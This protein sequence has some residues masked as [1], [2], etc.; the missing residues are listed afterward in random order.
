MGIR[1]HIWVAVPFIALATAG[2]LLVLRR[3]GYPA[4]RLSCVAVFVAYLTA[5]AAVTFFPITFD[6]TFVDVMRANASVTQGINLVPFRD[7][8]GEDLVLRQVVANILLGVPF[9]FGLPFLTS[10]SSRHILLWGVVFAASIELIQ[11]LMNL[12]YGFPYRLVDIDDFL[13]NLL[14]VVLGL[15]AF[16]L[17]SAG[18]KRLGPSEEA[19]QRSYLHRVLSA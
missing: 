7:L 10:G 13:L 5:V 18:Y 11:L 3:R 17:L 12:A 6:T 16:R 19:D 2:L 15:V 14:G 1:V 9:G 8:I 4:M